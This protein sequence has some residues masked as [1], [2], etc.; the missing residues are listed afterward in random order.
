MRVRNSRTWRRRRTTPRTRSQWINEIIAADKSAGA[1]RTDRSKYLAARATLET[2]EA[3]V[4]DVQCD[5]LVAPL[6]KTLKSK[7]TAMEKVLTVY[8]QAL[9][10][11][12]AE[13]TTAATYG[14]GELYGS[15]LRT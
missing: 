1:A 12:V 11:G 14:M 3:P 6:D 8:G 9:D 7:R 5:K 15:S 10:Y 13:V 4:A 2:A